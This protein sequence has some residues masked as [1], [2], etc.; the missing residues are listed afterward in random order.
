MIRFQG[1]NFLRYTTS[2]FVT[3]ICKEEM[4]RQV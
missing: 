3:N 4:S 2:V 1:Y